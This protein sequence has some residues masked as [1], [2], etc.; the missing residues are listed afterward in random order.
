MIPTANRYISREPNILGGEPII[1]GTRTPV[2][3]IIEIWRSGAAPE[4][5]AAS[6][7][8]LTL[9]QIFDALSY[10]SDNQREINELIERN[11]IPDSKIDPRV[12]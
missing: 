8:H 10:Y 5:I 7:P 1:T 6:L 2:R 3:A 11:R 4:Q 9:A 12:K